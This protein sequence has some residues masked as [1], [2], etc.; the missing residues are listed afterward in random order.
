MG[1][2]LVTM[3]MGMRGMAWR[4][5]RFRDGLMLLVRQGVIHGMVADVFQMA[6]TVLAGPGLY[7]GF[8]LIH[9]RG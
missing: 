1:R 2:Q 6:F 4:E 9:T 7:Y 3:E 5:G 8:F